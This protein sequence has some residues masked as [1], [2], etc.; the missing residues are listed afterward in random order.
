LAAVCGPIIGGLLTHA[1]LFGSSW[2]SV[3]LVNVPLGS[4]CCCWLGCYARIG[5]RDR[6]GWTCSAPRWPCS[7]PGWSCIR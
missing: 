1:D 2:R 5:H 4:A 6:V 3:F 7:A